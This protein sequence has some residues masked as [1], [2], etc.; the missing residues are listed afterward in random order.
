MT[1]VLETAK[2]RWLRSQ[3]RRADGVRLFCLPPAGGGASA[4]RGWSELLGPGAQ[5]TVVQLPGREDRVQ[6]PV[7][8]DMDALLDELVPVMADALD[9]P[10]ALFG[11]SLGALIAFETARRLVALGA[12]PPQ[13][14]FVSAHGAPH[15]PC[16]GRYVSSLPESDVERA[17]ESLNGL[18][19]PPALQADFQLCES[20]KYVDGP[21]LSCRLTVLV[22]ADDDVLPIDLALW[23]ELSIGPFRI[24]IIDGRHDFVVMRRRQAAEV[25]RA[26]LAGEF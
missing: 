14:L 18:L 23:R 8:S 3:G 16:R 12:P 6:E 4:F 25:I 17:M 2:T 19:L 5:V 1:T 20:Y 9:G 7:H 26:G 22:G 10:Y 13:H 11:H 24:R 15:A 21:P